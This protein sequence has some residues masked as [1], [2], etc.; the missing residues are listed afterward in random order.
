VTQ[1]RF[2]NGRFLRAYGG[3]GAKPP[4]LGDFSIKITHF[5][6]YLGQNS[7]FKAIIHQVKAFERHICHIGFG[8]LIP[9]TFRWLHHWIRRFMM[10]YI[11][12]DILIFETSVV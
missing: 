12:Y 4:A 1:Q 11:M 7:Y 2:L 8:V 5:Y 9:K 10:P 6:A 3:L